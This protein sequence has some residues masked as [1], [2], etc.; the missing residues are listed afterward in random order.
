MNFSKFSTSPLFN[1]VKDSLLYIPA[2]LVPAIVGF[3]GLSLYTRTFSPDDYGVYSLIIALLGII[4]SLTFGW[5]NSSNLRL[6]SA[7]KKDDRLKYFFSTSLF[8]LVTSLTVM[9]LILFVINL[10]FRI[11]VINQFLL[12]ITGMLISSALFESVMVILRANR[13][14]KLYSLSRSL[15]VVFS[16]LFSVF[17]IFY[18]GYGIT[19]ILISAI[20]VN[21]ILSIV[22][23]LK[24]H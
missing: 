17:L 8:V 2:I 14:V 10:I 7:Y 22:I 24:C 23:I 12:L 1:V 4:G 15:S 21:S 9:I 19:A 6:L 16:L 11:D 13:I 20:I 18:M 3:I 5:L